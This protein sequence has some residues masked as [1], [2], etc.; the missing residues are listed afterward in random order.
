[1]VPHQR[2]DQAELVH[3]P[4]EL[5]EARIAWLQILARVV[6]CGPDLIDRDA[7][8]IQ[9]TAPCGDDD[10]AGRSD[11]RSD[12]WLRPSCATSERGDI[13]V[14]RSDELVYCTGLTHS[15]PAS[16]LWRGPSGITPQG[17]DRAGLKAARGPNPLL[18]ARGPTSIYPRIA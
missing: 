9:E 2:L 14:P 3:A 6:L 13:A 11:S 10:H 7:L 16:R 1:F 18:H 15:A 17:K 8:N 4:G 5:L 12:P